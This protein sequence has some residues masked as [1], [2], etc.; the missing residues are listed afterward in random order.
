[1]KGNV[2]QSQLAGGF[3]TSL[4]Q[5]PMN[6]G[7][8]DNLTIDKATGGWSTRVGYEP[9]TVSPTSWAPFTTAGPIY[10]LHCAQDL[11]GG[12]RQHLY[13]EADGNL[14]LVF[15]AGGQDVVG[16][17]ASNRHVPTPTDAASWFTTTH[18]GTI[19]TNGVDRPLIV[20][21]WPI[22]AFPNTAA[23]L[24]QAVRPFGFDASPVPPEPHT[25]KPMPPVI[26]PTVASGNGAATLWCPSNGGAVPDGGRWGLG[27]PGNVSGGDGD[28]QA[29]FGWAVSF[30]SDTG[31]EGPTSV[32]GTNSWALEAGANGFRHACPVTIPTGPKGT[33]ARK[34]YR[35]TNYSDDYVAPGDTTLYFIDVVRNNAED[36]YFDAVRTSNLGQPAPEIPTGPLPA[37]R[38]RFSALFNGCLFLD[39]GVADATTLFYSTVGL[40]EQFAA[41]A[42]IELSAE[43]GGITALFGNYNTLL[44]FRE[45]GIDVVQGN[46]TDGF[47]ATALTSNVTC[48]APHSIQSVP[49]LGVVFLAE[50][51]VYAIVGGLTGGSVNEVINLTVPQDQLIDVITPD[52]HA[53]AVAAFSA[54]HREYHLYLPTGGNDRPDKGLVLHV[55]RLN[56]AETLSAWTTRTGFPVGAITTL[57]DG[58]LVFGHNTGAEDTNPN[59]ER[60]LFVLSAKRT[61]GVEVKGQMF[62]AEPAPTSTYRSA[63]WSAGDPQIQKQVSYVTVWVLTTG[64]PK[65]TMRHYKDFSLEPIVEQTYTAQSPDSAPQPVLDKAILGQ[66][67]YR[68]DRLVPLRFSVAHMS[69][70]WFCFEL[71]TDEDLVLV[72][73]EYEWQTKGTRVVAGVRANP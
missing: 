56:T 39:G 13:Y 8:A 5:N 54:Q 71:E 67:Q 60:G 17:L 30:V 2:F 53:K 25:V 62:I 48:K 35:T 45:R 32:L 51:G 63:W 50:D 21:P 41:D 19:I 43:N 4:P 55:D 26:G 61:M 33:V 49:G 22:A 37:P 15:E 20:R 66:G 16:L 58:T 40:I 72:G 6:A 46:Y 57:Y 24:L 23:G 42:F 12:A 34:I 18:Y 28:K 64:E 68:D 70:A 47:T 27:F 36:L 3:E 9:W 73:Y 14:Y 59:S 31:S 52:C 38:A 11:A 44:V 69:A 7:K 65:V 10:S 29:I 1:M